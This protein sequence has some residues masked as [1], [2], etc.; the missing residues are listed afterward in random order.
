[1]YAYF[2]EASSLHQTLSI[3]SAYA[4]LTE[5]L[6]V[7]E[8]IGDGRARAYARGSLIFSAASVA[9]APLNV[10]YE[11]KE[12]LMDISRHGDGIIR[13][14][15]YFFA[16][17]DYLYRG[18]SKE[19]REVAMRLIASGKE[20]SDPRSISLA[21]VVLG[22]TK[23]LDDDPAAAMMHG[24]ECE[25]VAIVPLDRLLGGML[26]ACAKIVLGRAREGLT[27]V[28]ALNSA[29]EQTGSLITIQ[30]TAEG[31][32]LLALGRISEGIR[33][34]E[35]QIAQSDAIGDRPRAAM[36]RL[37]L[38]E[39]YIQILSGKDKPRAAV[40]FKNFRTIIG[41][42]I[43]GAGR[44]RML[45][46]QAAAVE[47][48]SERGVV[49]ARIN[50]GFGQLSAMKRKRNEARSYFE[51]ARIGAEAQGADKLVQKI[52]AASAELR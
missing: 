23:L 39:V 26:K 32:G 30:G 44:A 29:L 47:Q 34:I 21:N 43:F 28:Y 40:L 13:S 10:V 15:G 1:M 4:M 18:L 27:E 41:V 46:Q 8:R 9:A 36:E 17:W 16:A 48:L 22:Y 50:L 11:T 33:V 45:L 37:L 14:F 6:T 25:S 3:R 35:R 51:R 38:A 2:Y 5:A 19:A 12:E 20:R 24:E 7:A 31:A 42:L 49:V 52:D